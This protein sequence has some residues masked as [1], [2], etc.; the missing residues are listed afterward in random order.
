MS[1]TATTTDRR[2]DRTAPTADALP[3]PQTP[4][5]GE[6]A[7]AR[8]GR[9][10]VMPTVLAGILAALLW[11]LGRQPLG[12]IERRLLNVDYIAG[13]TLRHLEISLLVTGLVLLIAIPGGVLL[14]RPFARRIR[15]V[16]L[17]VANAGQSIPSFGLLV[18]L[19]AVFGIIG[20][21]PAVLAITA[22]TILPVLRNTMTGLQQV[23]EAMIDAARGMG[24]NR[25]QVLTR[26]ELRLAVPVMLAGIRTA[27][28]IAVGTAALATLI[29][30]GGLGDLI[31]IGITLNRTSVLVTGSVLTAVLA[32]AVD[33]LAGIAQDV[34][35]PKGL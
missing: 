5:G 35:A 20:L 30:A 2:A 18:L 3:P 34:L 24:M 23:D 21:V 4:D 28:V 7:W 1:A 8:W 9:H 27:L 17:G 19:V 13:A 12:D 25:W 31:Y 26:V 10:L 22:Y 6:G 15:P 32:L 16:A 33:W 29:Q 14:T 11:W